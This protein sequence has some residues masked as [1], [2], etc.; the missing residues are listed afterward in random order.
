MKIEIVSTA[1][2]DGFT[3][4]GESMLRS[5]LEQ[6]PAD[7]TAQFFVEGYSI[8]RSLQCDRLKEQT[9][10]DW[11][12]RFRRDYGRKPVARGRGDD[13]KAPYDFRKD[14]VR[15]A[16][17]AAAVIEAYKTTS[18][19]ILIWVD[20]DIFF[21]SR[22]DV[23]ALLALKGDADIAWLDRK[24]LYPECGF[25]MLD[26]TSLPV[27]G[28]LDR[29]QSLI[30]TGEILGLRE[31]HDSWVFEHLVKSSN[32]KTASLSGDG[33]MTSHPAINGPLGAFL[34]H[35]KGPRKEA[36]RTP[37]RERTIPTQHPYWRS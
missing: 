23:Q 2:G 24:S 21:H 16:H 26:T 13:G 6:W 25:Y 17:K 4:Y 19:E 31:T 33:Y 22:V 30:E 29:W 36:G 18:A 11:L 10:P 27:A 7:V 8:P 14:A 5:F 15:F 34:D 20:A 32:A 1:H 3:M 35:M 37:K 28:V 12:Y 9:L